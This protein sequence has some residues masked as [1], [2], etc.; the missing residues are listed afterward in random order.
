MRR[1]LVRIK[2]PQK[3]AMTTTMTTMTTTTMTTKRRKE[4]VI[5]CVAMSNLSHSIGTDEPK[6]ASNHS[7]KRK[8]ADDNDDDDDD[9]DG[10]K[11]AGAAKKT[12][13]KAPPPLTD[14]QQ[15]AL[16]ELIT[17]NRKDTKNM[18][19]DKFIASAPENATL[20]K[21]HVAAGVSAIAAWGKGAWDD[22]A[23]H[24][25]LTRTHRRL[26]VESARRASARECT[27]SVE[28][29]DRRGR[30]RRRQGA[31][32]EARQTHRRREE[33]A[34]RGARADCRLVA[35]LTRVCA[36]ESC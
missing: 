13:K 5:V 28:S 22:L 12:S 24:H 9:D 8:N 6:A 17:N 30:G 1:P 26:A 3:L 10:A 18:L 7:K 36:G 20:K 2:T 11:G 34:R 23:R 29:K 32:Q 33:E 25:W 31:A 4:L 21:T 27:E 19:I 16:K 15:A 35:A 14:T